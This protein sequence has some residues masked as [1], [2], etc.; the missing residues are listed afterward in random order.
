MSVNPLLSLLQQLSE[1]TANKAPTPNP[2][3]AAVAQLQPKVAPQPKAAPQAPQLPTPPPVQTA[4]FVPSP[5]AVGPI[6]SA[7]GKGPRVE[8]HT[9]SGTEMDRILRLEIVDYYDTK[10]F[11]DL[12]VEMTRAGRPM[13]WRDPVSGNVIR[14]FNPTQNAA[15]HA[16]RHTGGA[17]IC[18]GAGV[19]KTLIGQSATSPI[20]S[21]CDGSVYCGP[22]TTIPQLQERHAVWQIQYCLGNP[23][24][25]SYDKLSHENGE[26]VLHGA[27]Q[28]KE[29]PIIICDEVH[30]LGNFMSGRAGRMDRLFQMY[31]KL[32]MVA[33][34]GSILD[35]SLHQIA[36][37]AQWALGE[38]SPIPRHGSL[39][40]ERWANVLDHGSEPKPLDYQE[41]DPLV[42]WF[43]GIPILNY[44]ENERQR[45]ARA[46]FLYR[47]QTCPGVVC[48]TETS[49][50]TPLL[51]SI[52]KGSDKLK[53]P[54][55][56]RAA[57][58]QVRSSGELSIDDNYEVFPDKLSQTRAEA[59]LSVGYF[60]RWDW[61][62]S[63]KTKRPIRDEDWLLAR[64]NWFK[65]VR[66]ELRYARAERYDT[67]KH[68]RTTIARQCNDPAVLKHAGHHAWL[69][70]EHQSKKRWDGK[71]QPPTKVVWMSEYYIDYVMDWVKT[72]AMGR[73]KPPVVIWYQSLAVEQK[74]AER[75]IEILT[76]R[77]PAMLVKPRILAASSKKFGEGIEFTRWSH[78][79]VI[80]PP[81]GGKAW[82]QLLARKHR[83]GQSA[84]E[85]RYTVPLHC[86]RWVRNMRAAQQ[87]A[88]FI[89]EI[90]GN[91][92]KLLLADKIGM[93]R[94]GYQ[95]SSA[96]LEFD[97]AE[98]HY[99]DDEYDGDD[100]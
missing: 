51:V 75:G 97:D 19:G 3:A 96:P 64:S 82:E 23:F 43:T 84:D 14:G 29:N 66:E 57:I 21:P 5:R 62:I 54:P 92:Q 27:I 100:I 86:E 91:A 87:N 4:T 7:P 85:V 76:S 38:Y 34:T 89:Y 24:Y 36:H 73:G 69:A 81:P 65:F 35:K 94:S 61:P 72:N 83:Y 26:A 52:A 11:P 20:V 48:T 41:I 16:R 44:D 18:A 46:A 15:L 10:R 13:V 8:V 1:R 78:A 32:R 47:L 77:D 90:T 63:E 79:L 9:A 56:L 60:Y 31:P 28:G 40:L 6:Y 68:V 98:T 50:G 37:I 33:M 45:V 17:L 39:E 53:M 42:I 59:Q 49:V 12:T 93:P 25:L 67:E 71:P 2:V 22:A 95:G 55:Q 88:A 99:D 80:E 30:R 58:D 74:L 70:W